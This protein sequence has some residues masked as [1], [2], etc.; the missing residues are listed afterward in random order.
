MKIEM[1][2]AI[3]PL[4]LIIGLILY[5]TIGKKNHYY[6]KIIHVKSPIKIVGISTKTNNDSFI[7]DDL[8][9]WKQ[10]KRIKNDNL[11]PNKKEAHSFISLRMMPKLGEKAWE[12]IIGQIVHDFDNMPDIFKTFEITDQTFV[13]V[14][15]TVKN[16]E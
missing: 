8:L 9:L 5:Y 10:F 12:Y 4:M 14:H 1:L 2:A 7:E 11:I 6:P 3:I 16:E 15:L 13:A